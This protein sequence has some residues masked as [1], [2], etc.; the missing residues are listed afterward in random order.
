VHGTETKKSKEK[1]KIISSEE[2]VQLVVR[3]DSLGGRSETT[4]VGFL[5]EVGFK[6]GVID[7]GSYG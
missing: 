4:G 1:Q 3:E 6:L 7:R 2:T 5:K